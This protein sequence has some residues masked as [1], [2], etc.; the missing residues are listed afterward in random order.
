MELTLPI[1]V[2]VRREEGRLMH[3]LW[4][5]FFTGPQAS[6]A[7]L[8]LAIGKL[9]KRLKEHLDLLGRSARHDALAACACAPELSTHMLKLDLNLRQP[10]RTRCRLLFVNFT[11]LERRIA[12]SPSLPELWFEIAAQESIEARATTVLEQYFRQ[13]EKAAKQGR[14]AV[15]PEALSLSAQAWV[16]TVDVEVQT[17]MPDP[18]KIERQLAMLLDDARV[19]GATE[20]QR[21]GRCLDWLYP[22]ELHRAVG[23]DDEVARLCELLAGEDQ[24]PVVLVG[25]RLVGKTTVVHECVRRR[26]DRRGKPYA[27]KRNVWLL[28]PQR[29]IS[30]MMYVGQWEGRVQA[31][32]RTSR[33]KQHVLFFDDFLGLYRA[34]I[35]RDASV[36]VA[37]VLRPY[38]QRRE[39]RVLAEMTP[40]AWQVFQERDRGLA[41]QFHVLR[42][43]T[44]G[45]EA[46][47]RV[48][49]QVQR[50]LEVEER[51]RF[52]LDALPAILQLQQGYI[53]DAAFPGKAAAFARHLAQKF[54]K[55]R[56]G[57]EQVYAEFHHKTGLALAMID[58]RQRLDR[59]D[60][61]QK[62]QHLVVGQDAAVQAAADVVTIA[63]ARLADSE[64]PLATMLF[65][66][67]TGVG[68]T[69]CAKALAEVMFSDA[70]RLLRFDMNE[71]S[72]AQ[73][74]ARLVGTP[75]EPE[76]LLTS[77]VRRQPFA[78]VLLDEIE[79]AHPDLFDLLLQVT[80]EGRLTDAL[81][82]TTD[83]SN[84]VIV[85]T[86][87][88]GTAH[89]G[90]PLGLMV[91]ETA[92][93]HTFIKAAENFFRPEFFNRLDHIIP[94]AT[95]TRMQMRQIAEMLLEDLFRR[96]GLVRR[97]SALRIEP[98]AME[99]II[100]A[101]YHPQFGARA[102]KR[103]IEQQLMQPVAASLAGVKP[104]LPAVINVY[105]SQ[106]G[107][108][109]SVHPLE[110][111]PATTNGLFDAMSAETKL[112][113]V[114]RFLDRLAE[115][116]EESRPDSAARGISPEQI[117]Y[118]AL[119]EQLH[120]TRE[121]RTS[122][123]QGLQLREQAPARAE[124]TP[125]TPAYGKRLSSIARA[126]RD[127]SARSVLRELHSAH[128][129]HDYL[130]E[131]AAAIPRLEELEQR[132]V[133]LRQ[134]AALLQSLSASVDSPEQVA[135]II[136]PL[137][138]AARSYVQ[139]LLRL[140]DVF[141]S[142]LSFSCEALPGNRP[143]LSAL[144]IAGPGVWPLAMLE[145]GVHLFCRQQENLLPVQVAVLPIDSTDEP[146]LTRFARLREE[147]LAKLSADETQLAEEPWPLGNVVRF[148]DEGGSTLDVRTGA[149]VAQFPTTNQWKRLLLEGLPL[150]P[151]LEA[152]A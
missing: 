49:I 116:V 113:R 26:V 150:P 31:I 114:D 73:A 107:I 124:S 133:D 106:R 149:S 138:V 47:R 6:D 43:P 129:I 142:G 98:A 147:W 128:D 60:V 38:I 93:Q 18:K 99:R 59:N 39:V 136:H 69:Q 68:K 92:R 152:E 36:C 41:D 115:L 64:R 103:A 108:A 131:S 40:E 109:A 119:K 17:Q 53:R 5:V 91:S 111:A 16:T 143:R 100:D 4:P 95:L 21:V 135:L 151:E 88:L 121:L 19:D 72:S 110:S 101:G 32:L 7:H 87:N 94:F 79:K 141:A 122:L 22:T 65:L 20:L 74:V 54:A 146:P 83:F 134:E 58:D 2:E 85:M 130:R 35:S 48:M 25:P 125:R 52:A 23:R 57:R 117:R 145:A 50:Q 62:L 126:H 148:Y 63:K 96:D 140:V 127:V 45:E 105:P 51:T 37:D 46:T 102:L 137:S 97:R 76:G 14:P 118:F 86:S 44:L 66:G 27:S 78:V 70:S 8:G 12:F 9:H 61:V 3:H 34:G 29:L 28:S 55:C 77:A 104:E 67:P 11:A 75:F 71:Y 1:Y 13:Q 123:G 139:M 80:G 33:K 42:I 81:G 120:R 24:R 132:F 56:I 112:A 82:R 15:S 10:G 90:R 84:T 89:S 30:G 144:R